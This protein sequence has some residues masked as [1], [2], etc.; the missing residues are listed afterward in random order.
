MAVEE[1][2]M[3]VTT[4]DKTMRHYEK[5]QATVQRWTWRLNEH[6]S[7]WPLLPP[8]VLCWRVIWVGLSVTICGLDVLTSPALQLPLLYLVPVL[9]AAWTGDL[10]WSL[11]LA[12]VC[13]WTG[14]MLSGVVPF[15]WPVWI[16]VLNALGRTLMMSGAAFLMTALQRHVVRLALE[17]DP[18]LPRRQSNALPSCGVLP[19]PDLSSHPHSPQKIPDSPGFRG[20][21]LTY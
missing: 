4:P 19:V 18:R 11:S 10:P 20:K 15:P 7:H 3:P 13:P 8:S 6:L 2:T 1:M 16:E 21:P 12:L 9:L 17:R 14:L 5:A